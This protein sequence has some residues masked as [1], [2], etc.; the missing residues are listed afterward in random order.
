MS[1]AEGEMCS[2]LP[3][4]GK[5]AY[6]QAGALSGAILGLP[7]GRLFHCQQPERVGG[8]C[9]GWLVHAPDLFP[10]SA[11]RTLPAGA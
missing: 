7:W 2:L 4:E 8:R 6:E 5:L 11:S 9:E 3:F 1:G 10:P